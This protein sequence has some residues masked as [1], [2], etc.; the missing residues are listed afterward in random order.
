MKGI[1]N[2]IN[3]LVTVCDWLQY[4]IILLTSAKWLLSALG[5]RQNKSKLFLMINR[6]VYFLYE[7]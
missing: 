5:E 3:E 7:T 4:P 2:E 6:E 1:K